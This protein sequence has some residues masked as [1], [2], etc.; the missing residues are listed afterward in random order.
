MKGR[1]VN[2]DNFKH[3]MKLNSIHH[4]VKQNNYNLLPLI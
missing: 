1:F 4:I 2:M 3:Y